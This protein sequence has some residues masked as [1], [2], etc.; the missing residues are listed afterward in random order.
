VVA[1]AAAAPPPP[2]V[3]EPVEDER[4]LTLFEKMMNMS[5]G[6]KPKP[7]PAATLAPEPDKAT[8]DVDIPPF[9]KRQVNN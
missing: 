3:A 2:P 8:P 5:R 1:P 6:P 4:P 7:A 9:F